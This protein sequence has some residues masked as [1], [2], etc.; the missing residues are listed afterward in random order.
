MGEPEA[1]IA[2][3]A[4]SE[5][6]GSGTGAKEETQAEAEEGNVLLEALEAIAAQAGEFVG[7]HAGAEEP[8]LAGLP[9]RQALP[10]VGHGVGGADPG[11]V[12]GDR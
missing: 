7:Q 2:G 9:S 1:G 6:L 10:E 8:G 3:G 5:P 4:P 12:V 11:Q